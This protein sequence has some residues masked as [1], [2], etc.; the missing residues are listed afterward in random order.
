MTNIYDFSVK[1]MNGEEKSLSDY[2][3]KVLLIVNTASKCGFTPQ[4]EGLQK[5]YEKY[6]EQDFEIL[7][8]PCNQFGH[9]DPGADEEIKQFCQQNYGVTF[10]MFSKIDVKGKNAHPLFDFLTRE[11]KGILGEQ[12]KW[13]FTKFLIDKDGQVV[14]RFGPQKNPDMIEQDIKALLNK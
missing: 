14:K 10:Q 7:G 5:L 3:E 9:Q 13:N 4:F 1:E 6:E 11:Q 8:F 2:K 12:I